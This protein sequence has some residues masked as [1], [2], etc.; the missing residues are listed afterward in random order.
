MMIWELLAMVTDGRSQVQGDLGSG[1]HF[2]G[3]GGRTLELQN[4]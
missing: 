1:L 4:L 2:C 3:L